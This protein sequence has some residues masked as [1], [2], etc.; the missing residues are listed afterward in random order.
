MM[1]SLHI[2]LFVNLNSSLNTWKDF[3]SVGKAVN[4]PNV[5]VNDTTEKDL[6]DDN[7]IP[8]SFEQRKGSLTI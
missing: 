4:E 1:S 8:W 5:N 3:V 6:D 7:D 2:I